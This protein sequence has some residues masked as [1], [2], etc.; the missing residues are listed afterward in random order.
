MLRAQFFEMLIAMAQPDR[1]QSIHGPEEQVATPLGIAPSAGR[2][3]SINP[4]VLET[5]HA[6]W[7][8]NPQP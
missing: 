8:W 2:S 5:Q 3:G 6:Q 4:F 1:T 7:F